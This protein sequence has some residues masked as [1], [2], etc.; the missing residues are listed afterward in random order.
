LRLWHQ[1][2]RA[3]QQREA[4]AGR[5]AERWF[6]KP[7]AYEINEEREEKGGTKALT[8]FSSCSQPSQNA[9]P[10]QPKIEAAVDDELEIAAI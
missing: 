3:E 2:G 5:T 7:Q 1:L 6:Y 10:G 9:N 8:S 4:T